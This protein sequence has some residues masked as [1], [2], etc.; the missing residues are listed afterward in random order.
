MSELTATACETS[1]S[2]AESGPGRWNAAGSGKE[3]FDEI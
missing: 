3:S 1:E 2:C